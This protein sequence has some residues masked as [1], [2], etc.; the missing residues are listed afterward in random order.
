MTSLFVTFESLSH[1]KA[2]FSHCASVQKTEIGSALLME[3]LPSGGHVNSISSPLVALSR[4]L[5]LFT[6]SLTEKYVQISNSAPVESYGVPTRALTRFP[7]GTTVVNSVARLVSKNLGLIENLWNCV[8]LDHNFAG[9]KNTRCALS[10]GR[11]CKLDLPRY[12][13]NLAHM[14][15]SRGAADSDTAVITFQPGHLPL[16]IP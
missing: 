3:A 8:S 5:T 12:F 13:E 15:G 16:E 4:K 10:S 2:I 6:S 14:I 1:A 9:D 11:N 7:G